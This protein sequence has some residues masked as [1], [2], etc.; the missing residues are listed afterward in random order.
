[1]TRKRKFPEWTPRRTLGAVLLTVAGF[2]YLV[3]VAALVADVA[4]PNSAWARAD[5][6]WV[7]T[8][9]VVSLVLALFGYG[10]ARGRGWLPVRYAVPGVLLVSTLVGGLAAYGGCS[11][12]GHRWWLA[13]IRTLELMMGSYAEPF[14]VEV[15]CP[16]DA[17]LVALFARLMAFS[18]VFSAIL[19]AVLRMFHAQADRLRAT[20]ADRLV[21]VF[22]LDETGVPLL[23]HEAR[24]LPARALL[25]VVNVDESLAEQCRRCG[26]VAITVDLEARQALKRLIVRRGK[27]RAVRVVL[28]DAR[29]EVNLA[30][31]E[32]IRQII[33]GSDQTS[34]VKD[35]LMLHGTVRIDDPWQAEN[36]RRGLVGTDWAV[37]TVSAI[38]LAAA[39]LVYRVTSRGSGPIVIVGFDEMALALCVEFERKRREA[40]LLG[41]AEPAKVLLAGP[42][43]SRL[44]A[45]HQLR[46]SRLNQDKTYA[47]ELLSAD[48]GDQEWEQALAKRGGQATVVF[49][50]TAVTE[51]FEVESLA[52]R[53]ADWS[54]FYQD[55]NT[56]GVAKDAAIANLRPFGPTLDLARGQVADSWEWAAR[57][58]H[59]LYLPPKDKRTPQTRLSHYEW[60]DLIPF[61]RHDGVRHVT[62]T[63]R[64]ALNLGYTLASSDQAEEGVPLEGND[65]H[66][67]EVAKV[68]HDSWKAEREAAGWRLADERKETI[69]REPWSMHPHP[70]HSQLCEWDDS[71]IDQEGEMKSI[72]KILSILAAL[73]YKL[74]WQWEDYVRKGEVRAEQLDAPK[75]WSTNQGD[76]MQANAGDWWV[77]GDDGRS[78]SITDD[79]FA[80]TYEPIGA[81]RYRRS[82]VFQARPAKAGE[83]V[84]SLEGVGTAAEGDWI[85]KDAPDN[86]WVVPG[87]HFKATYERVRPV[88]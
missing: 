25:V 13:L 36:W 34:R 9:V 61:M 11:E 47:V 77:T 30:L 84:R 37:G 78:W 80:T 28:A 75:Q 85:V 21:V 12:Q 17:P 86:A 22:G 59:E 29:P 16:A 82:G 83:Q 35:G 46:E 88:R 27:T 23:E 49:T 31:I 7:L 33:T 45:Q 6:G 66:V 42:T 3:G 5:S 19:A 10:R 39:Q 74:V 65:E 57:V 41:R 40:S 15:G 48:G 1:M 8:G 67:R 79:R 50:R 52:V 73:G 87:D 24:G 58:S 81:G 18:T 68:E 53:H 69:G 64:T 60:E 2:G 54:I 55:D 44:L 14:G 76:L 51:R 20:L 43:A 32:Q 4:A 63:I 72:R 71:R 62:L 26:A 56:L 70:T 38:E